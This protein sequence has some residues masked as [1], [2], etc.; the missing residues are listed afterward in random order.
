[1]GKITEGRKRVHSWIKDNT[2]SHIIIPMLVLK[3]G[4]IIQDDAMLADVLDI[5]SSTCNHCWD[6]DNRCQ[7]WNDE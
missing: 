4:K 3:L 1:M 5:I 6:G 7:C 2:N